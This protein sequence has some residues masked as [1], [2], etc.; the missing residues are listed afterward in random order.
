VAQANSLF[1]GINQGRGTLGKLA[2]DSQ[3][4]D[5]ANVIFDRFDKISTRMADGQGTLGKFSTDPTLYNNLSDSSKSMKDFLTE[6][7]KS[8]KKYLTLRVHLF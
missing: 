4:Y 2:T 7:K 8:P 5:R 1:D 6:F 3:L